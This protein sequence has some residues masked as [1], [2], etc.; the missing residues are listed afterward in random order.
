MLFREFLTI[1]VRIATISFDSWVI[2][3]I[4]STETKLVSPKSRNQ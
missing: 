1:I 3:A 2:G 4:L